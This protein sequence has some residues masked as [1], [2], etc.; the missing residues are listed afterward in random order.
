M[1]PNDRQWKEFF[2]TDIFSKNCISR[3]KRLTRKNQKKGTVPYVSSTSLNNG[4]I[5]TG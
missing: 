5:F 4:V 2:I 3:G 1:N